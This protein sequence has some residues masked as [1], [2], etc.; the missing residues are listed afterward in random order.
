MK[1]SS[2]TILVG[3]VVL[4]IAAAGVYG[5]TQTFGSRDTVAASKASGGPSLKDKKTGD[6][7]QPAGKMYNRGTTTPRLGF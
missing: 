3:V 2:R 6:A 5:L 4:A 7:G 1:L